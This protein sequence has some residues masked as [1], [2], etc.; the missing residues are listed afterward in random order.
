MPF[1]YD[2]FR[3]VGCPQ[4]AHEG[5]YIGRLVHDSVQRYLRAAA[6]LQID[7]EVLDNM[8]DFVRNEF[9]ISPLRPLYQVICERY[10]KEVFNPQTDFWVDP[11]VNML[12]GWRRYYLERI[13]PAFTENHESIRNV[14]SVMG[15]LPCRS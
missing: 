11:E 13:V 10:N 15:L 12:A 2:L 14:L 8:R 7:S 5:Q 3:F 9:Y 1:A 6:L 4:K